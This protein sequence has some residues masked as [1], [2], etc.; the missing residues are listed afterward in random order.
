MVKSPPANAG[1]I[2]DI[3]S[4]PGLGR[5]S[6]G[7]NGNALHYFCMENLMDRGVWRATAHEISMRS[8]RHD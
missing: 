2:R 6:G 8:Q 4:T 7:I 3:G 1:N 5:S